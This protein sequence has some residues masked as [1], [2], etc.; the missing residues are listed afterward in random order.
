MELYSNGYG[1]TYDCACDD[2]HHGHAHAHASLHCD[3]EDG[4][5]YLRYGNT[6]A[7]TSILLY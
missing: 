4:Y 1:S 3:H 7:F 5:V 6:F 2:Q